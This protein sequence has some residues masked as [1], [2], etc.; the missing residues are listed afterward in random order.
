MMRQSRTTW[1]LLAVASGL[2]IAGATWIMRSNSFDE[3]AFRDVEHLVAVDV[4]SEPAP[5]GYRIS[6]VLVNRSDRSAGA[7]VLSVKVM[8]ES[9]TLLGTNPLIN[10]L[11]VPAQAS[12]EFGA[13]VPGKAA[14]GEVKVAIEPSV[15]SW[16][17]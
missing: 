5:N 7:V 13:L 8:D 17:E 16:T 10:V 15:V 6:G 1:S 3:G 2:A 12:R 11:N 9:N 4:E 14:T